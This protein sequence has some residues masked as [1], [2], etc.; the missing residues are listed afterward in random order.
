MERNL[1]AGGWRLQISARRRRR[2]A[3]N[4]HQ[5]W[6]YVNGAPRGERLGP[7]I[8]NGRGAGAPDTSCGSLSRRWCSALA[9]WVV[10]SCGV[11][12][13]LALTAFMHWPACSPCGIIASVRPHR[14]T[15][16][17]IRWKARGRP[18]E[19][20]RITSEGVASQPRPTLG[21][22]TEPISNLGA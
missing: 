15:V 22:I 14:G 19:A 17:V 1:L 18:D 12:R 9:R 20:L 5:A 21:R 6:C 4:E 8:R 2:G 13:R 10:G 11:A 3:S 16:R 7:K